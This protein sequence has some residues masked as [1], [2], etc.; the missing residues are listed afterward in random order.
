MHPSPSC[1]PLLRSIYVAPSTTVLVHDVTAEWDI[2]RE[3]ESLQSRRAIAC[4]ETRVRPG[5]AGAPS[6]PDVSVPG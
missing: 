4:D 3:R 6:A 5:A 1:P 2:I